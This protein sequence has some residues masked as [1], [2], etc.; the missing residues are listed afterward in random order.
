[1]D[2]HVHALQRVA[3][4]YDRRTWERQDTI[5]VRWPGD[6]RY[7]VIE[8]TDAPQ[9]ESAGFVARDR[10]DDWVVYPSG[11]VIPYSRVPWVWRVTD[12]E[13]RLGN[14]VQAATYAA[15]MRIDPYTVFPVPAQNLHG[16][17]VR[18]DT[19]NRWLY[20]FVS[21]RSFPAWAGL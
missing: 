17:Q 13:F 20:K 19:D 1:M 7:S 16:L 4:L 21:P 11:L 3:G 6:G 10:A 14:A 5:V 15:R 8:F 9:D 2:P 18:I 12:R